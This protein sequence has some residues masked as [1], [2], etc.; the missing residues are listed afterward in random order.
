[1]SERKKIVITGA[2]SG[3]GFE[4]ARHFVQGAGE[5]VLISRDPERGKRALEGLR[6]ADPEGKSSLQLITADLAELDQVLRVAREL[7]SGLGRIDLLYNN[8][9]L[10]LTSRE[11]NSQGIEYT[12]ALNHLSYFRLCQALMPLLEVSARGRSPEDPIRIINTSSAAHYLGRIDLEHWADPA[13]YYAFQTYR[14]T[15]LANV[16]FTRRLAEI[17]NLNPSLPITANCFHPGFV[18]TN[19]GSQNKGSLSG[20]L[21]RLGMQLVAIDPVKAAD[22]AIWLGESREAASISGE[23]IERRKIRKPS[24]QARDPELA[25][26]LWEWSMEQSPGLDGKS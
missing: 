8:A 12:L 23:Y 5:I 19:F 1:M 21:F 20:A 18:R 13:R 9:G 3:I 2:S 16:L 25:R 15:K 6:K 10:Y 26:K 22:S 14:N 17:L 11:S 24:R 7:E 4:I